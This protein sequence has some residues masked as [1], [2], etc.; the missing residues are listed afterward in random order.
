MVKRIVISGCS[1][2]GKSALLAE[3]GMRGVTVFLEPGRMVVEAEL[4]SG[5]TNLPWENELG[6]AERV[7][8]IAIDQWTAAQSD[9]CFY[10]LSLLD[11]VT[12]FERRKQV[13]PPVVAKLVD[14]YHYYKT[15]VFA[16]PWQDIFA[17]DAARRHTFEDALAEYHA[18]SL[19]YPAKGY[20]LVILP[21]TGIAERADWL[22]DRVK[23]W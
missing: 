20:D 4:G 1:G 13:V 16:P 5:G 12:W 15:V 23:E 18:L 11:A 14:Q 7:I 6:F 10:D 8:A 19:S 21:K 22:L 3:L 17:S 2:G 9:I